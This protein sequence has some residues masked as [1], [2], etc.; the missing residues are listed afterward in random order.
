[1][2]ERAMGAFSHWSN[3]NIGGIDDRNGRPFVM[4][5]VSLAGYGGK[6]GSD[7]EEA[8]SLVYGRVD[9]ASEGGHHD[10]PL[11][12]IYTA[13]VDINERTIWARFYL[14]DGE[15]PDPA[16]G[17]ANLIFSKP[18]EFKLKTEKQ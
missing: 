11:R 12:T 5:D 4:Y 1:M 14:R 8:M 2:P 13:V 17:L 3:P 9:E 18:F 6:F 15:K 7:G 10:L 16:T